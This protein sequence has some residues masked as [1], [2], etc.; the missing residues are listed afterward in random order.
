MSVLCGAI[1]PFSFR[2]FC[3]LFL[4]M[5]WRDTYVAMCIC[6]PV[7]SAL[8]QGRAACSQTGVSASWS[9]CRNGARDDDAPTP[10]YA[11]RHSPILPDTALVFG[12]CSS[13]RWLL[14]VSH[15]QFIRPASFGPSC[16]Q[17]R[18]TRV[19][20]P[21]EAWIWVCKILILFYTTVKFE[22]EGWDTWW[23]KEAVGNNLM[24]RLDVDIEGHEIELDSKLNQIWYWNEM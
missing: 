1:C 11:D 4:T 18:K 6:A 13:H 21:S 24:L 23:N 2:S 22:M 17:V 20:I 9:V 19:Y 15:E 12:H 5:T 7:D 16:Y 8:L 14:H 3:S 10:H